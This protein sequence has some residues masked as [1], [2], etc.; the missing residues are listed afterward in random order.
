MGNA[1]ADEKQYQSEPYFQEKSFFKS[2]KSFPVWTSLIE[3]L[4]PFALEGDFSGWLSRYREELVQLSTEDRVFG[5]E[6][7]FHLA[8]LQFDDYPITSGESDYSWLEHTEAIW[9]NASSC[10]TTFNQI[11]EAFRTT[12]EIY[13]REHAL[14]ALQHR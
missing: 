3:R 6:Y 14:A 8:P 10:L 5:G 7:W 9:S 11:S 13:F 4:R 1:P 12:T 2:D